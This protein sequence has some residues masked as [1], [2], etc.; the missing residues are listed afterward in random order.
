MLRVLGANGLEDSV[1]RVQRWK[2][3]KCSLFFTKSPEIG[4]PRSI[5][6]VAA[7]HAIAEACFASGYA[8]A[9]AQ[10]GVD[11]KTVRLAW[12]DWAAPREMMVPTRAPA[13]L[14]L[15]SISIAGIERTL[16]T[17]IDAM[18]VVDVLKSSQGVEV[19]AWLDRMD[20]H[21]A[22]VNSV[23]LGFAPGLAQS[24]RSGFPGIRLMACPAHS[25]ELGARL[26]ILALRGVRRAVGSSRNV[27]EDPVVFSKPVGSLTKTERDSMLAW[28]DTVL[29]LHDAKERFFEALGQT[30]SVAAENILADARRQCL[31]I[32]GASGP[33]T[34]IETWGRA[35]AFGVEEPVLRSFAEVLGRIGS[36][37]G[38]R[39][40][41]L[42]FELARGLVVLRDGP[43]EKVHDMETGE[44][45]E[46]GSSGATSAGVAMDE[47]V[48]ILGG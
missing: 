19:A 28:D 30:S 48:A 33:A 26:F 3:G 22:D 46:D 21:G 16:V 20:A 12:L 39:R 35:I 25:A 15:H 43:R 2:C 1:V 36:L 32:E 18:A 6:S 9:S 13:F 24:L 47:V 17:D 5:A 31:A 27:H 10:F 45:D 11:E 7:R 14:G 38:R 34:F 4:R 37:W 8:H 41:S 29:S 42:P 44:R 40:P 23:A